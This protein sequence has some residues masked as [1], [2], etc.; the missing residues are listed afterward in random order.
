MSRGSLNIFL[1]SPIAVVLLALTALI[2]IAPALK[3][4]QRGK[5]LIGGDEEGA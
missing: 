4:F 1:A 5:N 3:I 2:L